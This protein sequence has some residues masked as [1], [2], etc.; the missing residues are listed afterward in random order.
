M[1]RPGLL[2]QCASTNSLI[3][4]QLETL[5]MILASELYSKSV[6]IENQM[7]NANPNEKSEASHMLRLVMTCVLLPDMNRNEERYKDLIKYK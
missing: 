1:K 4:E 2:R 7:K 5:G 6:K 3:Y